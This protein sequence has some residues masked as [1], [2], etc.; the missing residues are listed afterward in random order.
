MSSYLGRLGQLQAETDPAVG[1][2]S[3][4]DGIDLA[5]ETG[6][7]LHVPELLRQ[8]ALIRLRT[9]PKHPLAV[10]DLQAGHG[11]ATAQGNVIEQLRAAVALATLEPS[12]RPDDWKTHLSQA[13][14]NYE[15]G[16]T[17]WPELTEARSLLGV[18]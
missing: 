7:V 8:R 4:D 1:L 9:D 16:S 15:S 5:T 6:E 14:E 13:V 3:V 17:G 10:A 18:S 11:T 2:Q 12:I